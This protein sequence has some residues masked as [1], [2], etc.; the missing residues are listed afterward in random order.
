MQFERRRGGW[1]VSFRD[2][3][4]H[5]RFREFTFADAAKVEGLV[6]RTATRMVIED[7]HSFESGLRIGSGAVTIT[8]SE[9]Q[10][11]KLLC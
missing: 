4:S 10:Y 7:W 3:N 11:R 8:V 1:R 5:A 9:E 6:A 2:L